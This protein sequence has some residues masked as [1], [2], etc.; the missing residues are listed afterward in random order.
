MV[1]QKFPRRC[2]YCDQIISYD[3]FELKMGENRIQCP[4]CGK[5]YIKVLPDGYEEDGK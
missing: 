4:S 1:F 5:V 2:P 3:H